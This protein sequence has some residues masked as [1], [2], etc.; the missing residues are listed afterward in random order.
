MAGKSR[1]SVDNILQKDAFEYYYN[2][3]NER[4]LKAVADKFDRSVI[5]VSGWYRNNDWNNRIVQ[6]SI[7]EGMSNTDVVTRYRVL[8]T[9]LIKKAKEDIESGKIKIRNIQDL[10]KLVKLDLLLMGEATE[11]TKRINTVELPEEYR[12]M[13]DS[14]I[15]YLVKKNVQTI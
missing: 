15:E 3:G 7:E 2:L 6:R 4:T 12:V 9:V 11:I 1:L 14:T 10:E 13:L 5:T 8:N